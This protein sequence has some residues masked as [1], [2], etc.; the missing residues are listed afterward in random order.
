MV[1]LNAHIDPHLFHLLYF[2][3]SAAWFAALLSSRSHMGAQAQIQPLKAAVKVLGVFW[4]PSTSL[5][6]KNVNENELG[7]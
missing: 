7:K 5:Y 4:G 2:L 1:L 6:S 3:T